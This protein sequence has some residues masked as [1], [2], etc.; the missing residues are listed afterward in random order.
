[1]MTCVSNKQLW[2]KLDATLKQIQSEDEHARQPK[3]KIIEDLKIITVQ[4][5]DTKELL[6]EYS[7]VS[8]YI[9]NLLIDRHITFSDSYWS[10]LFEDDYK[11]KYS[12]TSVPKK[13]TQHD[14]VQKATKGSDVWESCCICNISR[15]NGIVHAVAP[16]ERVPVTKLRRAEVPAKPEDD[17]QTEE[18][19]MLTLLRNISLNNVKL[20]RL[21]FSKTIPRHADYRA[22]ARKATTDEE[23]ERV[24]ETYA[25]HI[26]LT[27]SR[28]KAYKEHLDIFD[29][30]E[31]KQ[32]L[33][34]QHTAMSGLDDKQIITPYETVM[35]NI[36]LFMG[37]EHTTIARALNITAKHMRQNVSTD[38]PNANTYLQTLGWLGRCPNPDCGI[39]LKDI[40][41]AAILAA[42]D[43]EKDA[44][45]EKQGFDPEPLK[46]TGYQAEIIKLKEEI[47][48]LKKA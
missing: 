32:I 12:K 1:M 45:L 2:K 7:D 3:A 29:I 24:D 31:L 42:D 20:A 6:I 47:K 23:K 48:A 10:S 46:V 43:P 22:R 25:K 8:A 19:E 9:R 40:A 44:E 18:P 28:Q 16:E 15:L 30:K 38:A 41:Q 27:K 21:V 39:V 33:L 37:Y 13:C 35:A 14:W 11:R 36:A 26:A 34:K 5:I 4:L 17:E